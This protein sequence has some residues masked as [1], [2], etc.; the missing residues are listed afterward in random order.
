MTDHWS[1]ITVSPFFSSQP[2]K[3]SLL[4]P[5]HLPKFEEKKSNPI[6][7][8]LVQFIVNEIRN[9]LSLSYLPPTRFPQIVYRLYERTFF[10][11]IPS[12]LLAESPRFAIRRSGGP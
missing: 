4:I 8:S 12:P 2:L 5:R 1:L 11:A 6:C 7:L 3:I 9:K 10:S